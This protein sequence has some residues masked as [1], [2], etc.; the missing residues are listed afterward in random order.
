MMDV[1]PRLMGRQIRRE[2][3]SPALPPPISSADLGSHARV[4]RC[5]PQTLRERKVRARSMRTLLMFAGKG[6]FARML[7]NV[8]YDL[9]QVAQRQGAPFPP[10]V[11][12]TPLT[13][14]ITEGTKRAPGLQMHRPLL[15]TRWSRAL[16][17]PC[18]N[19]G[20]GLGSR[21]LTFRAGSS[22]A[23]QSL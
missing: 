14:V 1:L 8:G 19:R 23:G 20:W 15:S 22:Q 13:C 11:P 21:T 7:Q 6:H 3:V 2:T 10:P 17:D 5:A 16:L 18:G 4:W 9:C 12:Q